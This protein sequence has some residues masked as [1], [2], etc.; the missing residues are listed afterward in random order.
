M[1]APLG[2]PAAFDGLARHQAGEKVQTPRGATFN[3]ETD[4]VVGAVVGK[5]ALR[6]GADKIAMTA[7]W[8]VELLDAIRQR[9]GLPIPLAWAQDLGGLRAAAIEVYPAG[10][11]KSRALRCTA[12]KHQSKHGERTEIIDCISSLAEIGDVREAM[13][14]NADLL[15]AVVCC[16]AGLDFLRGEAIPA[17]ATQSVRKEG[18]IWVRRPDVP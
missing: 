2:W 6:V 8:A 15:D 18:W 11:L 10:T 1:D 14:G 3:R 13:S 17:P 7:H 9:S 12:Y 4:R 5:P 16:L